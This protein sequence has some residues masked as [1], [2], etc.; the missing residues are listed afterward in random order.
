MTPIE[1]TECAPSVER[2]VVQKGYDRRSC[3]VHARA[4]IDH[5]IPECARQLITLQGNKMGRDE[6]TWDVFGGLHMMISN[7]GGESWTAPEPQRGL[8][9]WSEG[10]LRVVISDFT[11]QWHSATGRILGLGHTCRYRGEALAPVPRRRETVWSVLK[12]GRDHWSDAQALEM[13]DPKRFFSSGTGSIQWEEKEDGDLLVPIYFRSDRHGTPDQLRT[14]VLVMACGF[15]G[16]QLRLKELGNTLSMASHRGLGEPSLIRGADRYWMTLRNGGGAYYATSSDGLHFD[17]PTLW[18]FDDGTMLE[19]YDTQAHWMRLADR[20]FLVYT[21]RS[22]Q[23]AHVVRYRA[24]LWMAEVDQQR[25]VLIKASEQEVI[26]ERGAQLGNFGV[27]PYSDDAAL[28]C[29]SEWMENAGEWNAEVWSALEERFPTAD[30]RALAALPGR[31]G[32]CEL[33]GS[34]NSIFLAKVH[35]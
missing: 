35:L 4:V 22:G 34:D 30:L 21:R 11:P 19:S 26:P 20:L 1:V 6:S 28:I 17:A 10:E 12:P 25:G 8:A 27:T 29:V 18:R 5:S 33:S 14:E 13:P 24:P 7:D 23:N 3:W 15:D 9:P 32:L 31:C 16:E 2:R